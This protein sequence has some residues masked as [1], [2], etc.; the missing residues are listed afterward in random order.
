MGIEKVQQI[1]IIKLGALGDVLRTT[2]ILREL[3]GQITWVTRAEADRLLIE[4]GYIH[5]VVTPQQVSLSTAYDMVLSLDDEYAACEIATRIRKRKIIGAY[6]NSRGLRCYTEDSAGWF[7]M[8]LISRFGLK[9][10]N[11]LKKEN[12]K[13]YQEFVFEMLG[14]KFSGQEYILA[15]EPKTHSS[16]LC[17]GIEARAGDRWPMKRWPKYMELADILIS[18]M[19][20]TFFEMRN[21]LEQYIDDINRCDIIISGDT[22]CMHIGLALKKRVIALFGPTSSDEIYGYERLTKI[23]STLPCT[24]CYIKTRCTNNP[25]CMELISLDIVK[26]AVFQAAEFL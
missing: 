15:A 18:H 13:T 3:S 25:N 10:A 4:N 14:M 26:D 16:P 2:P 17:V 5:K 24:K 9:K 19:P 11:R 1:L 23:E 6:L 8:G 21:S 7:D 20:V 22:L 12:Q